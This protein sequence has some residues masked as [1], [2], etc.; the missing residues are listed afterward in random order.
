MDW[1]H[2]NECRLSQCYNMCSKTMKLRAL[3]Y[4]D[5]SAAVQQG[6]TKGLRVPNRLT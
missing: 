6:H 4:S 5:M 3:D 1:L 2:E